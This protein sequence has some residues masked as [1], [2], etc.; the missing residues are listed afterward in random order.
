MEVERYAVGKWL[1]R[2][3]KKISKDTFEQMMKF[4]KRN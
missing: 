3:G 2:N 1:G 4:V